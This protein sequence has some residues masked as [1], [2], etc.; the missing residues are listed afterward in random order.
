MK[1]M[2]L[3]SALIAAIVFNAHA[4]DFSA[5]SPSGQT[6]YYNIG[7]GQAQ[8]TY[9]DVNIHNFSSAMYPNLSGHLIIPDSVEYNGVKYAVTSIGA[10]SFDKCSNLTS[11]DIPNTVIRIEEYGVSATG[12]SSLIIPNSVTYIGNCAFVDCDSLIS[13]VIGTGITTLYWN[14]FAFCINLETLFFNAENCTYAG[15][16]YWSAFRG[17]TNLSNIYLGEQ[18]THLPDYIFMECNHLTD[19]EIY[20]T[21]P[22]SLGNNIFAGSSVTANMTVKVPCESL[23]V[24]Q[25]SWGNSYNFQCLYTFT[26]DI[27]INAN[28]SMWGTG[29][30]N[31][32]GDSIVEITATPNYGYHFDHW[33]YGSTANPDTIMLTEDATITAIFAKNQYSLSVNVNI[34][35]SGSVTLPLGNMA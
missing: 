18:V 29:M 34:D 4:Y 6:L 9:D 27:T 28:D 1:R 2:L 3:L 20:A 32:I 23:S 14:A 15:P 25:N 22:P 35:S 33:S 31:I 8:V 26:F 10:R 5:V 30:Y 19:L 12:L 16:S 24:Y 7:N 21:T 17:D 11:I 13:L